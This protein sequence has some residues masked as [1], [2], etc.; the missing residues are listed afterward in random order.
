MISPYSYVL[1]NE[2][3]KKKLAA[4]LAGKSQ[5]AAIRKISNL[6]TH[7]ISIKICGTLIPPLSPYQ[8]INIQK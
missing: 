8:Y 6:K 5:M 2:K 4:K 3:W 7:Q 1:M